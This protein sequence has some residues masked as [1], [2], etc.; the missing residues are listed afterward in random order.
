MNDEH[1]SRRVA[2]QEGQQRTDGRKFLPL[3]E[4]IFDARVR[5]EHALL[6]LQLGT[7]AGLSEL[8]DV[9]VQA[10]ECLVKLKAQPCCAGIPTFSTTDF[11]DLIP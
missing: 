9:L 11:E 4:L 10:V 7:A 2:L 5:F 6:G 3:A 8:E 1:S